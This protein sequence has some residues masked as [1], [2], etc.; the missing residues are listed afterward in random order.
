MNVP[1]RW[2]DYQCGDYFGSPLAAT[3]YFDELGQFWYIQPAEQVVEDVARDFLVIGGAGVDGIAWGYR[4][5]QS[6][7]WA[8]YP[9]DSEFVWLAPTTE[10]LIQGWLAGTI[11]V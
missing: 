1:H 8:W 7:L 5:G 4:R 2:R 10:A 3:G 11:T 6:G 9:I